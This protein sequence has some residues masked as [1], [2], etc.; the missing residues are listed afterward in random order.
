MQAHAPVEKRAQ[1]VIS[2]LADSEGVSV[3]L[4][5]KDEDIN[6]LRKLLKT[7]SDEVSE[8]KIRIGKA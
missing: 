4:L 6:E 7:K 8:S 5:E 1:V 3:K 2:E